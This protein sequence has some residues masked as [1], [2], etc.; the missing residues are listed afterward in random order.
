M[1]DNITF[2]RALQ[3]GLFS[4]FFLY[5]RENVLFIPTF[6]EAIFAKAEINK[7][8]PKSESKNVRF[9]PTQG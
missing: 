9:N 6:L 5:F 4:Q 2:S 1:K 3:V 7:F 8:S